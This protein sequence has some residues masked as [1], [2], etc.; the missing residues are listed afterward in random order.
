MATFGEGWELGSGS[1]HPLLGE[2]GTKRKTHKS[3]AA[4]IYSEK[5]TAKYV[6]HSHERFHILLS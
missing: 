4:R 2:A 3:P 6:A 1:H 5:M